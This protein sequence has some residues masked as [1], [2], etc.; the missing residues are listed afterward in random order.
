M[1]QRM[2]KSLSQNDM[3]LL[4]AASAFLFGGILR[5]FPVYLADFPINDGGLFYNMTRAIQDNNF[6][7]PK[8]VQYN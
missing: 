5:F 8:Y 1:V 3:G 7:L 2:R 4:L 6:L